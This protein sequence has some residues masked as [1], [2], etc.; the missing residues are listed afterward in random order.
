MPIWEERRAQS[1]K[2]IAKR[3]RAEGMEHGERQLAGGSLQRAVLLIR[4]LGN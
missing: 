3:Q 2:R 1:A 4:E